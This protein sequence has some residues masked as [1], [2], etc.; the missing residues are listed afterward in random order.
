LTPHDEPEQAP[1]FEPVAPPPTM[2]EILRRGEVDPGRRAVVAAGLVLALLLT[3][4]LPHTG[5]VT[6]WDVLAGRGDP[7][8]SI[9]VMSRAFAW[10]ALV[11]AAGVSMLALLARRWVLVLAAAAGSTLSTVLGF[12]AVWSRQTLEAD[13]AGGGAAAGLLLAIP[14]LMALAYT[15]LRIVGSSSRAD[16]VGR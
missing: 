10:S 1:L 2:A 6:G 16:T 9:K 7:A 12:S 11:L 3:F 8:H 15:L 14:V 5:P 13:Q 4:A